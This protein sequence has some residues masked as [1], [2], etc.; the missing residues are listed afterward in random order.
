MG[1]MSVIDMIDSRSFNV[2]H[3]LCSIELHLVPNLHYL[4]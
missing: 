4:I 1:E 2:I 3:K